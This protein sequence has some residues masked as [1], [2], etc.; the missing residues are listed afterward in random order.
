MKD[1]NPIKAGIFIFGALI[2]FIVG[3]LILGKERHI[4]SRQSQYFSTFKDVSGL[5]EGAPVR[6]GGIN[7]GRISKIAF[8]TNLSERR[9]QTTLLLDNKFL[10]RIR[11]DS[12][13]SIESQGLLGDKYLSISAGD[14]LLSQPPANSILKSR[15]SA[16][17]G[18]I[19]SKAQVIVENVTQIS[20]SLAGVIGNIDNKMFKNISDGA[21][22]LNS[23]TKQ[24]QS[25]D[26]LMHR[27]FYSKKD[28]DKII[29][30]LSKTTDSLNDVLTEIK[31][32]QGFLHSVIYEKTDEN[33]FK[34]LSATAKALAGTADLVSDIANE[35]KAG[36][37]LLHQVVYDET[38]NLTGV[39]NDTV[40][41]LNDSAIAI[42]RASEA[43]AN[44]DGT[45]GALLVDSKLYD[46]LV[47]VTDGAKRSIILRHAIRSSLENSS[48]TNSAAKE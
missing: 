16:D 47:E 6:L 25:G 2:A 24:I 4:F 45:I 40:K 5:S 13:V 46:N 22:G 19:I 7:V 26:G 15:D 38:I 33:L 3:V 18:N 31:S 14:P 20:E 8:S 17:I 36:K 29:G 9:V 32:G 42:K 34:N 39:L 10:D 1:G 41:K 43:L 11:E 21:E 23:L 37:G 12:I 35:V 27:L 30:N 28:A 44:G 48:L